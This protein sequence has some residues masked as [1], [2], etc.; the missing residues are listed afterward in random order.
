M[1]VTYLTGRTNPTVVRTA[2]LKDKK[3]RDADRLFLTEGIK[4]FLE[5]VESEAE[6]DRVFT[7]EKN[8]A[9]CLKHIHEDRIIC[10]S[11]SVFEKLSSEK[12]P[13]GVICSIKYIDKLHNFNKIYKETERFPEGKRLF[14]A[15]ALRDPGN[16]GTVI[17]TARAFGTDEVIFSRD[18]ADLYN[19]RTV[20]ASMGA[21]FRQRVSYAQSFPDAIRC[22]RASGYSVYAAMLDSEAKKLTELPPDSRQVFIIGN[23]GHGL[24]AEIAELATGTVYIP[25]AKDSVESLN[26]AAAASVFLWTSFCANQI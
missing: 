15:H 7:T 9:L 17:R 11:E 8:L 12:S 3:N 13:Q 23:E 14:M 16:L 5:A 1:P 21:L 10:V 18:C 2:A 24:P 22:L 19:A 4:L 6:I 20:R 26:A 25:M